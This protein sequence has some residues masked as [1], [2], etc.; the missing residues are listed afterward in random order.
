MNE[1]S[2]KLWAKTDATSKQWHP[3]LFHMLDASQ[4]ALVLWDKFFSPALQNRFTG[5]LGNNPE[6]ISRT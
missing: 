5:W 3:L 2:V 1:I 4:V 6:E